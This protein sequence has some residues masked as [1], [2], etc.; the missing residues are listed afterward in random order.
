MGVEEDG[1]TEAGQ[2]LFAGLDG[3][4][5]PFGVGFVLAACG[6]LFPISFDYRGGVWRR[7]LAPSSLDGTYGR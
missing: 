7:A 3:L 2:A 6:S 4:P 1:A 5:F